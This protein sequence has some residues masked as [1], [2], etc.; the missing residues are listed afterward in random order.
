M[1]AGELIKVDGKMVPRIPV[2]DVFAETF[3]K[4]IRADGTVEDRGRLS[5]KKVTTTFVTALCATLA[6]LS[7][8]AY[9]YHQSGTGTTAESNTDVQLVTPT[10]ASAGTGTAVPSSNTYTSVATISYTSSLAITEHGIF[11]S[12][13]GSGTANL[14]DRSVFSAINVTNGDS[15]QFTY[16][17]TIAAES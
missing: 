13:L 3:A 10:G 16:V 2:A 14:M 4:V 12:A 15:I 7:I 1:K 9:K 17:L 5:Q 6:S 11:D 8:N